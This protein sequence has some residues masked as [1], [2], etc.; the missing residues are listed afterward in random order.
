MKNKN[1]LSCQIIVGLLTLT[2]QASFAMGRKLPDQPTPPPPPPV[3]VETDAT[4]LWEA[5]VSGSKAW[6]THLNGALDTLGKDMLD[7][8]P[9]DATT[10]CGNYKSLS[11]NQRKQ[12]WMY[13]MSYMT[14]YE[15]GFNTKTSYTESFSDSSGKK[16]VSRGLL[17]I[18]IESG[19]AY[20]CDLKTESDL[21]DPYKNLDCG[22][23]ILNRW[24][25]RDGRFA[26]KVDGAWRGGARY[27]SVLRTTSGSYS[28]IVSGV[29]KLKMCTR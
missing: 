25:D 19:R 15:S 27:W 10:F 28:S 7:V 3:T 8:I 9:A 2:A 11:Y 21:H 24:L 6:T 13:L 14:K 4:P 5:K 1:Y 18:S 16:V 22:V 20:G 17:Q 12:F 23:R 29:S 26:G